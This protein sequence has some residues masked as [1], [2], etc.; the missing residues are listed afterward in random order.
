MWWCWIRIS[1]Q[2]KQLHGFLLALAAAV[3]ETADIWYELSNIP[4][5][6]CQR[7]I[8]ILAWG[9]ACAN[10][11]TKVIEQQLLSNWKGKEDTFL[12]PKQKGDATQSNRAQDYVSRLASQWVSIMETWMLWGFGGPQQKQ[13]KRRRKRGLSLADEIQS[14]KGVD[15]LSGFWGALNNFCFKYLLKMDLD[16]LLG[17]DGMASGKKSLLAVRKV[18]KSVVVSSS[19]KL[20]IQRIRHKEK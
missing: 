6:L 5:L 15:F 2:W 8:W 12:Q 14:P 7:L 3:E 17:Q 10:N 9:L 11:V 16:E 1:F 19:S 20:L 4:Y 13:P 18:G